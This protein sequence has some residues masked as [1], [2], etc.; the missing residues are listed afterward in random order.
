MVK[1]QVLPGADGPALGGGQSARSDVR[2]SL[3][4]VRM[5]ERADGPVLCGG[6]S[7]IYLL[8]LV[9]VFS[10]HPIYFPLCILFYLQSINKV[11]YVYV[12]NYLIN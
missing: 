10:A 8:S 11:S 5:S 9:D 1:V 6:R 7:A 4:E 3:Q 12:L 2:T